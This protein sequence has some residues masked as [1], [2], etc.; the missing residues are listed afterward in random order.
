MK[1]RPT[2][3]NKETLPEG[4]SALDTEPPKIEITAPKD[5]TQF[6]SDT[7]SIIVSAKAWDAIDPN[8]TLSGTG[9]FSLE[10]G[11]N[12]IIVT[13]TDSAGNVGSTYVLV[14]KE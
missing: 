1:A 9:E 3:S 13:A 7:D 6:S 14:E 11:F 4:K 5:G 8:P 2:E 12:S 10:Q